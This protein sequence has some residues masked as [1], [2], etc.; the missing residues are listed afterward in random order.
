ML[1]PAPG[2]FSMMKV[3]PNA[4][5]SSGARARAR[6]SVVPPGAKGTTMRTGLLGQALREG[7]CGEGAKAKGQRGGSQ[8][9]SHRVFSGFGEPLR[10]ASGR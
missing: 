8:A 6:M 5:P 3:W 9:D 1:P 7:R 10:G 2:L 4:L